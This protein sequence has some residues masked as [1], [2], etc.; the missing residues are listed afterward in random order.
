[1]RITKYGIAALLL[2][3][4][5]TALICAMFRG[6]AESRLFGRYV[7]RPVPTSVQ[8][9]KVDKPSWGHRGRKFVFC[10][11]IGK[12][13]VPLIY[14]C[15]PFQKFDWVAYHFGNLFWG[16]MRDDESDPRLNPFAGVNVAGAVLYQY[17]YPRPEW[18]AP[19]DWRNAEVYVFRER[20]EQTAWVH[21]QILIYN[22]ESGEAY[23]VDDVGDYGS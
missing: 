7:L 19:N 4:A 14:K 1:M 18:F 8:E 12:A 13:D 16:N 3:G 5:G 20:W 9:I 11:R 2:T 21:T 10:F 6:T 23:F 15:R 17:G 22:D